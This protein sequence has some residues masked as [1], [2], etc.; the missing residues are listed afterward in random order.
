MLTTESCPSQFVI[1][2]L[3]RTDDRRGFPVAGFAPDDDRA[4]HPFA[5]ERNVTENQG[6]EPEIFE[7]GNVV[8]VLV[9]DPQ[10]HVFLDT[11]I[12]FVKS[13]LTADFLD[14][15]GQRNRVPGR[16]RE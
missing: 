6:V 7:P 10:D 12:A 16:N 4:F 9:D 3:D 5:G 11:G 14:G 13:L 1:E 15:L 8:I 2:P